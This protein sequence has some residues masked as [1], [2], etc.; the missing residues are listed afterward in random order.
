MFLKYFMLFEEFN[1]KLSNDCKCEI[2]ILLSINV[3]MELRNIVYIVYKRWGHCWFTESVG[4]FESKTSY[5]YV[6]KKI[7][8]SL[9]LNMIFIQP[10]TLGDHIYTIASIETF[11]MYQSTFLRAIFFIIPSQFYAR[12]MLGICSPAPY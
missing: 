3:H 12:I 9:L 1:L 7:S 4:K 5:E 11:Y 10:Q 6:A 8:H 2:M